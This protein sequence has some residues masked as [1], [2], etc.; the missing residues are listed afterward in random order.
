MAGVAPFRQLVAAGARLAFL[1]PSPFESL[2]MAWD[3]ERFKG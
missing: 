2:L 1:R 3:T